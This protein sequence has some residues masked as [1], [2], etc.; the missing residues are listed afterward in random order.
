VLPRPRIRL[1]LWSVPVIVVALYAT[2]SVLRGSWR[3]ELPMDAVILVMVVIVMVVVHRLR[4][5]AE[6]EEDEDNAPGASR[7]DTEGP[8]S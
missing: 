4:A 5:I 1:P 8:R 2:R 6:Q 7:D 3:L